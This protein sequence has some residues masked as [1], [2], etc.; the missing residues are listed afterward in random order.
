MLRVAMCWKLRKKETH[1]RSKNP[2][3]QKLDVCE[4]LTAEIKPNVA[5]L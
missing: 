2:G 3:S 1:G 4:Y 5:L